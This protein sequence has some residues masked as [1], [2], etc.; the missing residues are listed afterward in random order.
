MFNN[1]L[2]WLNIFLMPSVKWAT[3]ARWIYRRLHFW[4]SSGSVTTLFKVIKFNFCYLALRQDPL[5]GGKKIF[6]NEINQQLKIITSHVQTALFLF[7]DMIFN[8][9]IFLDSLRLQQA[10]MSHIGVLL[11]AIASFL[12]ISLNILHFNVFQF[13]P[14]SQC[15]LVCS[16]QITGF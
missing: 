4:L 2:F 9:H 7:S 15:N 10:L 5:A 11:K 14:I 1:T 13:S 6:I 3:P 16:M 12:L 8:N